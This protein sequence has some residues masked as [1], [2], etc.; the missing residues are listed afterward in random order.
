MKKLIFMLGACLMISVPAS[1]AKT[2][3]GTYN[4]SQ[5]AD[6]AF[7]EAMRSLTQEGFVLK[8]TDKAQGTIQADRMAWGSGTPAYSAFITISK[9]GHETSIVATF[10]K[11]PGII[12]HSADKWANAF[13]RDL[14]IAL[15][16]L[17]IKVVKR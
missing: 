6:K 2:V 4:T 12:G 11:N 8:F 5:S 10:T 9:D 15:H 3:V 16:D 13:G 17:C 1:A 7:F 14:K